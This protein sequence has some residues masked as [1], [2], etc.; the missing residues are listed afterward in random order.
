MLGFEEPSYTFREPSD[1]SQSTGEVCV[2]ISSG[3]VAMD[4]VLMVTPQFQPGTAT[5]EY[6]NYYYEHFATEE[7][8][9]QLIVL[10]RFVLLNVC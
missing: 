2:V 6:N 1:Q 7:T 8:K 4:A 3:A 9:Y 5:R 10:T